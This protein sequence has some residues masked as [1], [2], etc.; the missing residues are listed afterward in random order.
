MFRVSRIAAL[1]ALAMVWVALSSCGG[2]SGD[3][4]TGEPLTDAEYIAQ[5]NALCDQVNEQLV[6][7][8]NEYGGALTQEQQVEFSTRANEIGQGI[9]PQLF[10]LSPPPERA[11]AHQ[12][13]Q[14]L[15][16]VFE[17]MRDDL[18]AGEEIGVGEMSIAAQ[19]AQF[20][21]VSIWPNCQS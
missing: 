7:L 16:T 2:G 14:D 12:L 18:A 21:L 1:L 17:A 10:A 19:T 4:D 6:E 9:F 11:D 20:Q 13:A 5:G 8:S 3:S 15:F